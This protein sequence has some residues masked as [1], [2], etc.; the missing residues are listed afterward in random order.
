M[1]NYFRAYKVDSDPVKE[2]FDIKVP[3]AIKPFVEVL[4]TSE[5]V[6]ASFERLLGSALDDPMRQTQSY[7]KFLFYEHA[8]ASLKARKEAVLSVMRLISQ[9]SAS[10][11]RIRREWAT[12]VEPIAI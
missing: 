7:S 11:E 4:E 10:L 12:F 1:I 9:T 3:M 8:R 5:N 2:T 6:T